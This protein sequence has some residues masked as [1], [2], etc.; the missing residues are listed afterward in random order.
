MTVSYGFIPIKKNPRKI[1]FCSSSKPNFLCSPSPAGERG[2]GRRYERRHRFHG[3]RLRRHEDRVTTLR[4]HENV[5]LDSLYSDRL[6]R[7]WVRPR[8]RVRRLKATRGSV[9]LFLLPLS[10]RHGITTRRRKNARWPPCDRRVG[11]DY[12]SMTLIQLISSKTSTHFSSQPP[13]AALSSLS[14][15]CVIIVNLISGHRQTPSAFVKRQRIIC[16][17]AFCAIPHYGS[18][19]SGFGTSN[20]ILSHERL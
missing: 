13:S 1:I 20:H 7:L 18:E 19:Q 4:P 9:F 3:G 11:M 15:R 6:G 16:R 10:R 5:F 17:A 8:A 2:S 12:L 14:S